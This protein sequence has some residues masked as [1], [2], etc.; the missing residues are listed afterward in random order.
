MSCVLLIPARPFPAPLH[1]K[2]SL[3][4]SLPSFTMPAEQLSGTI[5]VIIIAIGVQGCIRLTIFAKRQ[6]M[7]FA[8]RNRRGPHTSLGQGVPK[9]LRRDIE[10]YLDYV[11]Y[12]RYEPNRG[13]GR[14]PRSKALEIFTAFEREMATTYSTNYSRLPG[15]NVRSFLLRCTNGPLA[16][17]GQRELHLV[18]DGYEH[19]RHRHQKFAQEELSAFRERLESLRSMLH[20]NRT[21]KPHPSPVPM[22][23]I[24]S[25]MNAKSRKSNGGGAAAAA[26]DN[27]AANAANS[28]ATIGGGAS[29]RSAKVYRRAIRMGGGSGGGGGTRKVSWSTGENDVQ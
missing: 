14:D 13:D 7:R 15:T 23:T 17:V 9:P 3:L 5:V 26:I 6:I 28:A 27:A 20:S 22:M 21:V 10:R 4:P 29:E 8:L 24:K 11:P 12:I 16:G 1:P 18:A 2:S 19:A 25:A